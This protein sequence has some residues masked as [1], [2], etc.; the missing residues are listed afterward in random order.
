M[1]FIMNKLRKGMVTNKMNINKKIK[2][3]IKKI[4][5]MLIMQLFIIKYLFFS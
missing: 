3:L 2:I 1:S 4:Y 5:Y